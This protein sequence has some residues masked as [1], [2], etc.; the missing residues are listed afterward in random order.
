MSWISKLAGCGG[1]AESPATAAAAK[2]TSAALKVVQVADG[3]TSPWGMAFN[4]GL[5]YPGW[6]GNLFVGSLAGQTLWRLTLDGQRITAREALLTRSI[7]RIRHV[8]QNADGWLFLLT[9][10]GHIYRLD[11]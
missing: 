4:E 11:V 9:D 5:R 8:V 7:G 6:N 3:L 10:D 2:A 1:G